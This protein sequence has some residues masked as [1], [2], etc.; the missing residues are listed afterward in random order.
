MAAAGPEKWV[1]PAGKAPPSFPA[2][3]PAR[4]ALDP[5][6]GGPQALGLA[7]PDGLTA[8]ETQP[9]FQLGDGVLRR[10][11]AGRPGARAPAL[12]RGY[13]T[14]GFGPETRPGSVTACRRVSYLNRLFRGR[15]L[16]P[17]GCRAAHSPR[18][19]RPPHSRSGGSSGA[20]GLWPAR[21]AI[22]GPS[23]FL[24]LPRL[25]G[26]AAAA[27]GGSLQPHSDLP[28]ACPQTRVRRVP[29]SHRSPSGKTCQK[30]CR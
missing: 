23:P 3:S 14:P 6:A 13:G 5:V 9:R 2:L 11:P 22:R 30:E 28:A 10:V 25:Q 17:H 19:V 27:V 20:P 1:L 12:S 24:P 7:R 8:Q 26:Q 15:W 18:R 29:G 21:E 4:G 16:P